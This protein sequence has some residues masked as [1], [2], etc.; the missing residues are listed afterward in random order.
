KEAKATDADHQEKIEAL[1][2]RDHA[3][4][5]HYGKQ[6]AAANVHR[7]V[8]RLAVARLN[9]PFTRARDFTWR[10]RQSLAE[11]IERMLQ[12]LPKCRLFT[13]LGL[14]PAQRTQAGPQHR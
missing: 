5:P 8:A 4:H 3:Q 11:G 14:L 12:P 13:R 10:E 2:D 9:E 7:E 6:H 1:L